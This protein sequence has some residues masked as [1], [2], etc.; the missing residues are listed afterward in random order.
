MKPGI[1]KTFLFIGVP[2][3]FGVVG[4]VFV[5]METQRFLTTNSRFAVKKVEVLTKGAADGDE[6]I[7]LAGVSPGTNL[8]TV[9]L[10]E[11]RKHVERDPWVHDATVTRELPNKIQITYRSQDP[12]AILGADSMYYLNSEGVP[13]YRVQKGDSL[14]FPLVQLDGKTSD[15]DL[16]KNRVAEAVKILHRFQV[17][18]LFQGKDLG[19]MTVIPDAE[20][21]SVPYLLTLRF[22]PKALA[23]K[24]GQP[25]R[26]Y[27]V[28]LGEE[29]LD[30]QVR[31]WEAVVRHL[32]QTGKK[33]R[34]I[35]LEL[36]KK[37]VVKLER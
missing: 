8:F 22:P 11:V 20:E 6:L 21:G 26:L 32:V 12:T 18:P 5:A 2:A 27:T 23:K 15:K 4:L 14:A 33:P 34:L 3:A 31:H 37:V 29:E 16:L 10:E 19:D 28:S 9:D 30:R 24:D 13:F 36:G 35:R 17:S 25:G 1:A 7:R